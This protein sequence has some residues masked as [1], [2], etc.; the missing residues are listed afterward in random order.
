MFQL[1]QQD[2]HLGAV[3]GSK[4]E[5]IQLVASALTQAGCVSAAYVDG[6][7]KRETQTST[8]LGNGI[9]IPHGTTDTRDLVLKTGVQVFQFPQ[10]IAWGDD[11]TAYVV[12]GIAARSDEHLALLRQLTHVLSD[13]RVA[14]RLASTTSVEE[15]RSL[16][17]GEQQMPEFR[18]DTSLISLDVAT[19]NLLTL[20]ALN[21]GRLQQIGAAD[22]SFVS[23]VVSNKPLNLGQGVWFSD[24][25]EG[26][27]GSAAAVARPAAPFEADGESVALLVTVAATD[28]QAYAP[29]D[30]LTKLLAEQK[31]ERLLKA[32]AATLLALLTSDVPE[33]S[34]VQTAEFTVRNEHGLHAR[35]GTTLV[36]VIKQFSS[37]I[38]VAN[39]NGTGKPVNGRSL[40]KVIALGVK[41]GHK[42]RFT[43]SGDDAEQALAAIGEAIN[44][45]LGEGAA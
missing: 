43:A 18:F 40:M 1:S 23:H 8:Y 29:I 13:D 27:L 26:N 33:E 24:S 21:A 37:D 30:Y 19:D 20:Q 28:D 11:Q 25:A 3:A 7:L 35:P 2:I 22:A 6:M 31:A 42:L 39:L 15:L 10:G 34:G 41:K 45:G 16:L 32:D 17:M 44:S 5:A 38:T 9:A 36:N 14:A 12:L 4:Q